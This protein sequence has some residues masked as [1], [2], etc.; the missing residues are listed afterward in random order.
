MNTCRSVYYVATLCCAF[1]IANAQRFDIPRMQ[2]PVDR[3][4]LIIFYTERISRV[5]IIHF[6]FVIDADCYD[7]SSAQFPA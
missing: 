6:T 5:D 1:Y 3:S 4:S 7:D 2:R